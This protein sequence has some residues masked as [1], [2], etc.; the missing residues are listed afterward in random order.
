MESRGEK[1]D[2]M[3]KS[4]KMFNVDEVAEILGF[5]RDFVYDLVKD[6]KIKAYKKSKQSKLK[7]SLKQIEAYLDSI[8][9]NN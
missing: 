7:F 5:S 2:G 3:L 6:G 1:V 4:L 9:V 8:E